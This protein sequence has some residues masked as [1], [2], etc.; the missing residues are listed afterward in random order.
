LTT[1]ALLLAAVLLLTGWL[2]WRSWIRPLLD[3][4][5]LI[6]ALADDEASQPIV[7]SSIRPF[8]QISADL[9]RIADRQRRQR[10]QLADE[11]FSLRAILGSMIEGVVIVDPSQRIRLANDA[12]Y[13]MFDLT[14]SPINRGVLEVFHHPE[15]AAAIERSLRE[16]R[17]V[18]LEMRDEPRIGDTRV[19]RHYR[20][21][22]SP[23]APAGG[24]TPAGV[25][26]VFN[27]VTEVRALETVRREFVANVSHE[28]RTPLAIIKGYVETLL[29]GAM[30]DRAMAVRSLEVIQKH[31]DR[32][33]LLID[34]LLTVSRMEHRAPDLKYCVIS[35]QQLLDRVLEQIDSQIVA[36][37]ARVEFAL[38]AEHIEVD[39]PRMEQVFFNLFTNALK[40]G[41]D[42][43]RLRI[44]SRLRGDEIEI[45]VDDDGPGIPYQD[46]PHIF[47]RFYRVHKDRSRD[48]GGTGLGLSIVKHVV[49]AHGGHVSVRST[50]GTGATFKIALPARR[51]SG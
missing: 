9:G 1:A 50:P 40:Y 25:L 8:T 32:L 27:D 20:I 44:S 6:R 31:G 19:E 42:G 4:R 18:V 26:G 17:T 39:P 35:L 36:R 12:L 7:R 14:R 51:R 30:D 33:N 41:N 48:A 24:S 49:M 43:L 21:H 5:D 23:L 2:L 47:E 11:G 3:L 10:R 16:V 45:A 28:F 13:A 38:E 34:D 22:L 37:K 15:L 46:Q 29:D